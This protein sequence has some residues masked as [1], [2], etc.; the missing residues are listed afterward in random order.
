MILSAF[1]ASHA[2]AAE[3]PPLD[4]DFPSEWKHVGTMRCAPKA[5]VELATERYAQVTNN[6][7]MIKVIILQTKNGVRVSQSKMLMMGAFPVGGIDTALLV[8]GRVER[9]R[10]TDEK[11][12]EQFEKTSLQALGLTREEY[13]RCMK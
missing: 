12:E 4:S 13:G 7:G 6:S 8:D 3:L 11:S 9:V 5:G 10:I 1:A 2:F